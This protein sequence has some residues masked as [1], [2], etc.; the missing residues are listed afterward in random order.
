MSTPSSDTLTT[1]CE[2]LSAVDPALK[3]AYAEIGLP[4]WRTAEPNYAS[5]ARIIAYQQISTK[6]AAAIWGRFIEHVEEN[7]CAS[8]VLSC[9]D[10]DLQSCG[11]SRPKVRYFKSIAE[12]VETGALDFDR[13]A[14]VDVAS[15]RKELIAVKGIGVWTAEVFLMNAIGKLDAFPEGDVGL[16]ESYR[17]LSDAEVREPS[18]A[19]TALAENW[20]PYRGVAA[21]LLWG[22]I[23]ATRD[24]AYP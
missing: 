20:R 23:N 22:W 1:A 24:K 14:R 7:A 3:R 13:L 2:Q 11:L 17:L 19:F 5:L 9:S 16:M 4:V 8:R 12:A 18:K 6:A 15:A 10:E 21:H